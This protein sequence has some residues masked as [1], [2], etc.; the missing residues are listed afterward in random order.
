MLL[1]CSLVFLFKNPSFDFVACLSGIS[2]FFVALL[3]ALYVYTTTNQIEIATMQLIE[4]QSERA[5]QQ[6]PLVV[7]ENVTFSLE[8]PRL[9]YTP[10][11]DEYSYLSRYYLSLCL[12]NASSFP[13]ISLEVTA[14][15]VLKHEGKTF[16]LKTTSRKCKTLSSGESYTVQIMFTGDEATWLFDSLREPRADQ[17]PKIEITIIYRNLC[18]GFFRCCNRTLLVPAECN[19]LIIKNWHSRINSALYEEK[20][21]IRLL[22]SLEIDSEKWEEMFNDAK[23]RFDASLDEGESVEIDCID[24]PEEF[25]LTSITEKEYTKESSNHHFSRYVHHSEN[26]EVLKHQKQKV[27]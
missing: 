1:Y 15:I 16:A 21:T 10:P 3:T 13:A 18:G 5:L 8:R 20:E 12:K 9:F 23:K 2:S 19:S 25:Q 6:Q 22:K 26:C 7:S 14:E 11:S 27:E 24:I 17:L 4:M